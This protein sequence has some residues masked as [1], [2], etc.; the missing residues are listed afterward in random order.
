MLS[1]KMAVSLTSLITIFALAFVVPPAMAGDFSTA[2]TVGGNDVSHEDGEQRVTGTSVTLNVTF[3]RV[4][5]FD[6][7]AGDPNVSTGGTEAFQPRDLIVVAYNENGAVAPLTAG[8][9]TATIAA[10]SPA[11]G[12][13][14]M[15]TLTI[16]AATRKLY[17]QIPQGQV[18]AADPTVDD[19]DDANEK[20]DITIGFIP[21]D[22]VTER[23]TVYKIALVGE[24]FS[25]ITTAEF[26]IHVLLSEMPKEAIKD[27]LDTGESTFVSSVELTS[28]GTTGPTFEAVDLNGDG[29][30]T[31]PNEGAAIGTA[32][33]TTKTGDMLH[34]YLVTLKS[35]PGEKSVLIKVKDFSGMAR[36]AAGSPQDMYIQGAATTLVEGRQQLTVKTKRDDP[37]TPKAAGLKFGLP[38]DKVIPAGGFLVV[39]ED[40]GAS[41][42]HV[43]PGAI[44]ASPKP[45][46][47]NQ[48]E[49]IYNVID[50]G[51]LPNLET[52]LSNGGVIGVMGP[53]ALMISEIMW[54]SDASQ[55]DP[56]KSQWIELY[57]AGVEYKT[58]DGDNTTYLVFYGPGE[59]PTTGLHDTVGTVDATGLYWSIAGK[60]QSGRSGQGEKAA[61]LTAVVPTVAIVSMYRMMDATGKLADGTMASSWTQSMPPSLNFDADNPGVHI[62]TPGAK[63]FTRPTPPAAEEPAPVAVVPVA[64][65]DEIMISEIMVD[66]DNGRLPQWI[67]LTYSGMAK[68]S[69]EGWSIVIDNAIDA[70]VLG[71]G[72]AITV[73]L[74]DAMV[75]VSKNTGN[76]GKGQSVLVVAWPTTR[77]SANIP[78]A[79]VINVA[80][81][82]G[83]TSRYQ[84]LSY[85]GF[86][87]TLVPPDQ[88]AIAAFGDIAGNLHEDW[89]IPMS[90]GSARSSLIR[91]DMLADGTMTM[92]TD[93]NGWVLADS[94]DL[95]TGP[96]SFYGD[97]EDSS[98]PGQHAGGPLPVELSHFRPARDKATGAV[99]ITW[100][101]QSE[102]NNAGFFI[103]RSQQRD[104]EFK[105]IN[106]TMVPGAGTTSEKQFY[107]YTDTTA[108]PNV[109]YYYQ[110]ED[111]SLDGNRQTLTR[112]IRLKGHI[113]AAGK[114]T[115]TW[116]ELKSSNE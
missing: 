24:A 5:A 91:Y 112:G 111:V 106:A 61:G 36:P 75:D 47:R 86:R 27:I 13:N 72:N 44:D 8:T 113:G 81:Q 29:D 37:K 38:K 16:P 62:G 4:V 31:D 23:P 21:T 71:G 104:G 53:H 73:S 76:M 69:L 95:A 108:Q 83:Q 55:D 116:G 84:L 110:I 78:D 22:A 94:T 90:E 14:Y 79:R 52:F 97:D 87:I 40:K 39:T 64:M 98:T 20:K 115:S 88:E 107:T 74:G 109:V 3:G 60:G 19:A 34:L 42:V 43:P 32:V 57:N 54:G 26:Q 92:G 41:A 100:A 63:T 99:V 50:D 68:A 45:H 101:T 114:L 28:P 102:L 18:G 49:L 46:E 11:N 70:G 59:A 105:V 58:Q 51:D 7:T 56:G 35:K 33:P 1:K 77:H 2:I 67:E 93:A 96:E 48:N 12:M 85:N 65:A 103:K 66:T 15:V 6:G 17:V 82:L 30:T 9:D 80:S 89:D 10:G 25:T